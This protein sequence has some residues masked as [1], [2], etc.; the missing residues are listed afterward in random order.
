MNMT[1]EKTR[2][3]RDLY[4]SLMRQSIEQIGEA[5]GKADKP[6]VESRPVPKPKDRP[7]AVGEHEGPDKVN[8]IRSDVVSP[9]HIVFLDPERQTEVLEIVNR[10]ARKFDMCLARRKS[11]GKN[12]AAKESARFKHELTEEVQRLLK[13]KQ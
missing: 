9:R 7:P 11:I 8:E 4:S 1:L 13:A 12:L 5:I 6:V 2:S 10:N 3:I